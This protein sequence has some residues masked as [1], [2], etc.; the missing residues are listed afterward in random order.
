MF[1]KKQKKNGPSGL[2][3]CVITYLPKPLFFDCLGSADFIEG[4]FGGKSHTA[5]SNPEPRFDHGPIWHEYSTEKSV[6]FFIIF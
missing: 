4:P 3:A 5:Q 1:P 6:C 2:E